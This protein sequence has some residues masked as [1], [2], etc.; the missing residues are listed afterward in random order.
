MSWQTKTAPKPSG[1]GVLKLSCDRCSTDKYLSADACL[2][3][4]KSHCRVCGMETMHI[5][6]P[7]LMPSLEAD[8]FIAEHNLNPKGNDRCWPPRP[9]EMVTS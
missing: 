2:E 3:Q 6:E 7:Y 8:A 5:C 4:T 1:L 9:W